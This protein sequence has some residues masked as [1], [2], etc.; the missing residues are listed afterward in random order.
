MEYVQPQVSPVFLIHVVA[1][2]WIAPRSSAGPIK[3][4]KS[5]CQIFIR[6]PIPPPP[7]NTFTLKMATNLFAETLQHFQH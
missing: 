4:H 7:P 5:H 1:F 2:H 3:S 6:T